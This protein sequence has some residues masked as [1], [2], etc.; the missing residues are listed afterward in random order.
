MSPEV[1]APRVE[2]D[3]LHSL[4]ALTDRLYR[5]TSMDEVFEAGLDAITETL[6]TSRASILLFDDDGV[7]RFKAAR[8]LSEDY[9]RRLEGHTPW[10]LG[11]MHPGPIFVSDIEE[12]DEQDWVKK[13]IRR[14]GI[15][16]LG[17]I[18]LT[19]A[20]GVVGK[21]MT[22]YPERRILSPHETGLAVTIARQVGFSVERSRIEAMR[23]R[24]EDDL[25]HSEERFR[26]MSEHAPVMI[27]MS[28]RNGACLQ[29][30]RM[31]REAWGVGLAEVSA[32]DWR[33]TMHPDDAQ[34]IVDV[35]S[36]ATQEQREFSVKGRYRTA[37]GSTRI[38]T[39]TAR[40]HFSATG[41]FLGMIGV[42]VDVTEQEEAAAHR[43]LI[44]NEL[45]HRVK[46]TLALVQAIAHRTLRGSDAV[47]EVK[48]FESR[49]RNLAE[50]HNLLTKG[51][52]ER[53][54]LTQLVSDAL[55]MRNGRSDRYEMSGPDVSL[56]P[57]QALAIAMA[58]HE[59]NT[60]AVKYGALSVDAGK[61]DIEW[62]VE[63]GDTLSLHWR[64]SGGPAVKT[65]EKH[66]FGTFMIERVLAGDLEGDVSLKFAPEGLECSVRA[67]LTQ[68]TR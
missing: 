24:A 1:A 6:G 48:D 4:Y 29:L 26:L 46:N 66:G 43:E 33:S 38:F 60:N 10:A 63:A 40:P 49:L 42:N 37:E 64:E 58:L 32:F 53:A 27:W 45:N 61:V 25:R 44:F 18:P 35:V 8:G 31:L 13:T 55:M 68:T 7:M 17:F 12:T 21:F 56:A 22:Y 9:R 11:E 20:G 52:W 16:S 65:P 28:D 2:V 39:T 30:N 59:L 36:E 47:P 23:R 5:A 41:D 14:E 54:P 15:R 67:P 3:E 34:S 57:K 50:A 51:N 19:V 62:H